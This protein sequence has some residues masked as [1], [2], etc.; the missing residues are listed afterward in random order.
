MKRNLA[1]K[2]ETSLC[3]EKDFILVHAEKI[4]SPKKKSTH[5]KFEKTEN[6]NKQQI[7]LEKTNKALIYAT[8][9]NLVT[10]TN[11]TSA[12]VT[13]ER[14]LYWEKV[15]KEIL[16]TVRMTIIQKHHL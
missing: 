16:S 8:Q 6:T 4:L 14:E 3:P 9:S 5:R 1:G 13:K 7:T 11:D 10:T 15:C 2:I 12:K